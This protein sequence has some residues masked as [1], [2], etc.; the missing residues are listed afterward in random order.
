MLSLP[1][2]VR[3][4]VAREPVDM[5]KSFDGLSGLARDV[6]NEDPHSGHL[7]VFFNRRRNRAKVLWWDRG[8]YF[9]LAKRLEL[10]QFVIPDALLREGSSKLS[11]T[12]A[13]LLLILEGLDLTHA[14]KIRRYLRPA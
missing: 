13:E 7:F 9:L 14:R 11:M 2:S 4:F 1:P 8:G 3:L 6:L 12:S 10:G 5:R